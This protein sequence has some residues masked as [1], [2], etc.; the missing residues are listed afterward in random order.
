[1]RTDGN[2]RLDPLSIVTARLS[3]EF[4]GRFEPGTIGLVAA[5]EIASLG[6]VRI[7]DFVPILAHRRGRARLRSLVKSAGR[8][9]DTEGGPPATP[10]S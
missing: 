2:V 9:G 8:R 5:E 7:H 10:T 4:A 6:E 1:M 3:D